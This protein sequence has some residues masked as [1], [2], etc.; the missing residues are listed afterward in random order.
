MAYLAF[1]WLAVEVAST[2]TPLLNFPEWLPIVVLWIAICGFPLA[3]AFCWIY[4]LTR[5]AEAGF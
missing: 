1:S 2:V 3:I 4:E 5:G